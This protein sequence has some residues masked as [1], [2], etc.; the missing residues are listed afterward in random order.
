MFPLLTFQATAFGYFPQ[1]HLPAGS[2]IPNFRDCLG[3]LKSHLFL[4][5]LYFVQAEKHI[6]Q[7]QLLKIIG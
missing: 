2:D 3:L 7:W 6:F 4:L 1:A 5:L